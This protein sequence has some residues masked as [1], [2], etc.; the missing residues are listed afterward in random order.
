MRL[1]QCF[2]SEF[3]LVAQVSDFLRRED[4]ESK[5]VYIRFPQLLSVLTVMRIFITVGKTEASWHTLY[6]TYLSLHLLHLR[7]E[8]HQVDIKQLEA[9]LP[10]VNSV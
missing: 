7:A 1:M 3:N 6:S 5:H 9:T 8:M 2:Q 10:H 4:I